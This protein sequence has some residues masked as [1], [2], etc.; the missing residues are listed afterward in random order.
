[1]KYRYLTLPAAMIAFVGLVAPNAQAAGSTP[2][3]CPGVVAVSGGFA[4]T[5]DTTCNVV[6]STS[7]QFLD[8]HQHTLTGS[9][10][11]DGGDHLT[12][13]NGTLLTSGAFL[14]DNDTFSHVTVKE[15]GSNEFLVEAGSNFRFDHSRFIDTTAAVALDFYFGEGGRVTNSVFSGNGTALSVQSSNSVDIENN[16]F[17]RNRTGVNL[18]DEDRAGVNNITV[19]R[20]AFLYNQY[21]GLNITGQNGYG[22]D[23]GGPALE[24]T[25]V[26]HNIF[27]RNA[28]PGIAMT[29]TCATT[30]SCPP[31]LSFSANILYKNGFGTGGVPSH[32]GMYARGLALGDDEPVPAPA[33]LGGTRVAHNIA[34][35]NSDL[36]FDVPGVSDGGHNIAQANGNNEQCVGLSCRTIQLSPYAMTLTP[37]PDPATQ[38][39]HHT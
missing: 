36:G 25:H 2:A 21:A 26:D 31:Q 35:G 5:H 8:L 37:P 4:L 13:K 34:Y 10:L 19:R 1:M 15:F 16:I 12:L 14:G 29:I 18:W 11:T 38:T 27:A 17:E 9:F 6:W 7:H 23:E 24:N 39:R 32:S 33:S 3:S 22:D 28:G 30:G 20:N